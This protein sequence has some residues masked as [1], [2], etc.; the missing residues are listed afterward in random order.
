MGELKIGVIGAGA[1][2]REHINR[3]TQKL[4]GGKVVAI[5]DINLEGA[6]KVA[7]TSGAR[8]EKDGNSLINAQDVDA[9]IVTSWGP[10][11][12]E[13]VLGAIKAGKPVFVR[14]RWL[15]PQRTARRSLT[16]RWR[17]AG[18]WCK[19]ALCAAMTRATSR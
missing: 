19:S 1:I 16:L 17:L 5:A 8:V 10:A 14:S 9:V 15:Q 2:G 4:S 13:S 3:I 11:H 12:A 7:E 6:R 18:T